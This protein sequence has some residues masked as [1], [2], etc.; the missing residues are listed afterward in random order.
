MLSFL[1]PLRSFSK[2]Q[3]KQK[4]KQKQKTPKFEDAASVRVVLKVRAW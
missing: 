3:Q 4:Q 1:H 2:K